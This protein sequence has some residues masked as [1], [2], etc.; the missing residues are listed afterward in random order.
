MICEQCGE[1]EAVIHLTQIENNEMATSHLCEACAAAKGL[2]TPEEVA[3]F[4]LADFLAHTGGEPLEP[5]EGVVAPEPCP[6]CG[7]TFDGFREAGRLGCPQCY[8]AF[9]GPLRG[10]DFQTRIE[11]AAFQAGGGGQ[12][13]AHYCRAAFGAI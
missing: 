10:L 12:D 13:T 8:S 9:E 5:E 7:L 1:G 4:P 2:E 6:F 11:R 3:N